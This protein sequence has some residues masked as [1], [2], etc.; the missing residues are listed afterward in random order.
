MGYA[1]SSKF[2]FPARRAGCALWGRP[3][4]LEVLIEV[5]GAGGW[6]LLGLFETEGIVAPRSFGIL[7][8]EGIG[9]PF[10]KAQTGS[11]SV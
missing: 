8:V 3:A 4:Q 9:G 5:A 10:E 6:G 2:C 11:L 1:A 7:F